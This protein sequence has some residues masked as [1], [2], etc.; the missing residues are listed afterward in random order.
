MKKRSVRINGHPTSV[1]LEEAFWSAL[2]DIADH[3]GQSVT[4]LIEQIDAER[5]SQGLSSAIR[6]FVL[7]HYRHGS[8]NDAPVPSSSTDRADP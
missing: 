4:R 5:R 2:G 6:V 8:G 3:R 1:S 7:E